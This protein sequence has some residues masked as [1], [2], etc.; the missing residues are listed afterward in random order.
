MTD[1]DIDADIE[2]PLEPEG[3]WQ[4]CSV[5]AVTVQILLVLI[6]LAYNYFSMLKLC[7]VTHLI[8]GIIPGTVGTALP[9]DATC[10]LYIVIS[11]NCT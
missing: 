10:D 8:C 4:V 1:T 9:L 2:P 11:G 6:F 3:P 7:V 5:T